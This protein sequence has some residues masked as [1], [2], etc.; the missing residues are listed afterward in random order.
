MLEPEKQP[1]PRTSMP[2]PYRAE[3]PERRSYTYISNEKR[4]ELIALLQSEISIKNAAE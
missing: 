2:A 4:N 3:R 1:Q